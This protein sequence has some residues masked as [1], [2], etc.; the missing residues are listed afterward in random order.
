MPLTLPTSA[1][2]ADWVA[3]G[4]GQVSGSKEKLGDGHGH[5]SSLW[6]QSQVPGS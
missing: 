4:V 3:Q 1:H 2:C 5:L 6:S